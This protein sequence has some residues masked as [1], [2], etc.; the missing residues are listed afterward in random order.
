MYYVRI[1]RV[2]HQGNLY[3]HAFFTYIFTTKWCV[4]FF[5]SIMNNYLLK[6]TNDGLSLYK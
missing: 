5:V 1:H 2:I 3:Y 4:P 6:E